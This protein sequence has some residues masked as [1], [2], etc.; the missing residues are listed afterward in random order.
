MQAVIPGQNPDPGLAAPIFNDHLL[1]AWCQQRHSRPEGIAIL[2][3]S[4]FYLA[5]LVEA[6]C[7]GRSKAG[8]HVLNQHH[9]C[10]E[11]RGQADQNLL[12]RHRATG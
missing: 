2:G 1:A 6:L 9:W 12:Q 10:R 3:L 8:G 4:H 11:R 7:K 5:Q